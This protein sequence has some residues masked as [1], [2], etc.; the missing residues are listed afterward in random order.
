VEGIGVIIRAAERGNVACCKPAL[1]FASR[2]TLHYIAPVIV[3]YHVILTFY[4]FWLPNDPR[5]SWSDFVGA[6]DLFRGYGSATKTNER[7]SLAYQPHDRQAREAAK[8]SLKYPPVQLT[9][10]QAGA[11][12]H[13]FA[14]YAKRAGL[15]IWACAILPDHV[16]LVLGL[17]GH[18]VEQVAIQLKA[19]ATRRLILEGIHPLVDYQTGLRPPKVFARGQWKVF[20]DPEDVPR[21]I[22]YV[23]YNPMKEG[24]LRQKWNCVVPS[25]YR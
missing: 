1:R 2:L 12:G 7:Q 4:G 22:D 18:W 9:G 17:S 11:V 16:H 5:G 23:E 15:P 10:I 20:L 14:E 21:A 25:I 24:K 19:A 3:A 8:E 13:G 6:W